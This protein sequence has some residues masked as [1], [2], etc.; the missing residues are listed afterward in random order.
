MV[1]IFSTSLIFVFYISYDNVLNGQKL[2]WINLGFL[3]RAW[4][5]WLD[6]L[7]KHQCRKTAETFNISI[8][9]NIN[10]WKYP[11]YLLLVAIEI[12]VQLIERTRKIKNF[13]DIATD[14]FFSH[15][16]FI[17]RRTRAILLLGILFFWPTEY[18]FGNNYLVVSVVYGQ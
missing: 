1:A 14:L 6:A 11:T 16:C 8:I 2:W 3:L 5:I 17:F 13:G 15:A 7:A 10:I 4:N 12:F 9:A 18:S